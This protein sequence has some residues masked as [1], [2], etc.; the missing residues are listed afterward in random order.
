MGTRALRGRAAK[1]FGEPVPQRA[2]EDAPPE[3]GPR[4][5][6]RDVQVGEE[7]QQVLLEALTKGAR[8]QPE[9]RSVG[10]YGTGRPIG[11]YRVSPERASLERASASTLSSRLVSSAAARRP[12]FVMR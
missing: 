7:L 3:P 9:Q 10:A 1:P 8:V 12:S 5:R 2:D 6:C 4:A 11:H